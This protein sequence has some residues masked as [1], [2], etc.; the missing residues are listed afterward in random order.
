MLSKHRRQT[1]LW[2]SVE[3]VHIKQTQQNLHV[4]ISSEQATGREVWKALLEVVHNLS[5]IMLQTVPNFWKVGKGYMEGKYQ[6]RSTSDK[7][8]TTKSKNR[9]GRRSSSQVKVMTNEIVNTYITLLGEFFA[10]SS[11]T[12]SPQ[13]PTGGEI[14]AGA[15][16]L[17]TFVAPNCNGLAAGW[18]LIKIMAELSECTNDIGG[19]SHLGNE[20]IEGLKEFMTSVKWKFTEAVCSVWIKGL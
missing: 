14:N 8:H 17:P 5:E 4:P 7:A 2:V 12:T 20:A 1:L 10:L 18:W 9:E 3:T 11:N 6:S 13:V 19:L 16:E 15:Q